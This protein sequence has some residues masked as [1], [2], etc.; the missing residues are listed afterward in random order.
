MGGAVIGANEYFIFSCSTARILAASFAQECVAHPSVWFADAGD[1]HGEPAEERHAG[2]GV[3]AAP[4]E[5]ARVLYPGLPN[6]PQR[7]LARRQMTT[8]DGA[9]AP[10]CM[11]YFE[12]KGRD[13]TGNSA[14]EAAERFVDY[15][16]EKS[17]TVTLAVSLGR[18]RR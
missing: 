18:S 8:P 11:L 13:G 14:A 15:V 6:F 17:Y 4:S 3:L 10:G 16:A 5:G 2:S 1:T 7:E 9:F 12:L